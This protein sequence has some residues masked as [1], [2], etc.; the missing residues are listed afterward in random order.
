MCAPLLCLFFGCDLMVTENEDVLQGI[1]N[2]R[3]CK[4]RKLVLK[5]GAELEKIK[6]NDYWVH[7]VGTD[8]IEYS[9]VEW[10][11][12]DHF[13]GKFRLK[14]KVGTFRGLNTRFPN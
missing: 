10:Q 14:P 1:A 4:F 5:Q 13:V 6:M 7:A 8:D 12:C 9:E 3:L 2:W 11:D